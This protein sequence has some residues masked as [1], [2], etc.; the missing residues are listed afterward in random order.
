MTR[1]SDS[2]TGNAV[3]FLYGYGGKIL[4]RKTNGELRYVGGYTRVL[5]VDR[6]VSFAELLVKFGELC[7]SS[8]SLRC[9][10]PSE[11][12]DVL[13]SITCDADLA[14]VMEE[15]DRAS[16]AA[17]KE[18]KIRAILFPVKLL[19]KVSPHASLVSSADSSPKKPPRYP[20]AGSCPQTA[21]YRFCGRDS[22]PVVGVPVQRDA[23]NF[24]QCGQGLFGHS[25]LV[26]Y[27][28]QLR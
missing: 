27:R 3:K 20:V 13:V 24:R 25:H 26:P 6:A 8:M 17:R 5:S 18:V 9:K 21:A 14:A 1:A 16:A 10:L 19:K 23:C 12:L 11:D 4:P 28:S 7:G 22:S 2:D 15:Y